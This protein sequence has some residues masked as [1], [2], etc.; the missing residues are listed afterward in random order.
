MRTGAGTSKLRVLVVT[1]ALN[2]NK[3]EGAEIRQLLTG[4]A[5]AC[6]Y[7]DLTFSD[8]KRDFVGFL[9]GGELRFEEAERTGSS[10]RPHVVWCFMPFPLVHLWLAVKHRLRGARIVLQPMAWLGNDFAGTSWF[11]H[12]SRVRTWL[13]QTAVPLLR[14]IWRG[15]AHMQLVAAH[16][17]RRQAHLPTDASVLV[18]LAAPA[19]GLAA[20]VDESHERPIP[21]GPAADIRP[22]ALVSRLDVYR[23]GIDR[24]CRWVDTC[25]E[26]LPRPAVLLLAPDSDEAPDLLRRLEAEGLVEWDRTTRGADLLPRLDG[27]RGMLLLTRYE[28]QPR[29]LREAALLGMPIITTP[30]SNFAEV[31]DLLGQGMVVDGDDPADVQ[32][33]FEALAGSPGGQVTARQMF[34]RREIGQ[35]LGETLQAAARGERPVPPSYYTWFRRRSRGDGVPQ[36]VGA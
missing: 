1:R 23:K 2:W 15:I 28:G 14:V 12:P 35:Y 33:A 13:K 26:V 9:D 20:A 17:E 29:G 19:S 32:R 34:D 25:R 11:R 30:A 6:P 10:Q 3:D 24:M 16:E 36:Q 31:L 5:E 4:V 7:V 18:P 22:V 27:C 21:P 8:G